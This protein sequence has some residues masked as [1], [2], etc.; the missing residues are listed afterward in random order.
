M[1]ST[2]CR[3]RMPTKSKQ[4]ICANLHGMCN[5]LPQDQHDQ[6]FRLLR[7]AVVPRNVPRIILNLRRVEI[8]LSMPEN[9]DEPLL[10]QQ[11]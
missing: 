11:L 7:L 4:S 2:L 9:L 6:R 1:M 8:F 5:P 10:G 3:G